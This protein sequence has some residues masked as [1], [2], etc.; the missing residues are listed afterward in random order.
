[1]R[2]PF[3]SVVVLLLASCISKAQQPQITPMPVSVQP[4]TGTFTISKNT[5]ITAQDEADRKSAAFLNDYLQQYYGLKLDVDRQEGKDYIR[6]VTRKFIQAPEKDAYQMTVAADGVTIEGDTYAGTFYG[7]QSLIQLLPVMNTRAAASD[8]RLTIPSVA[9]QDAPRFPY[10]GLHLDVGRHMFPISFIKK[11]ID[12]IALHKMNY[13]HWH[14]TEDQG[15]RIEIKK[16][17]R[18]Q[19]EAA[20]RNGTIIGRYPGTGNDNQRYGGYYT[21]EEVKEIVQYAADR[22]ITVIPEIELPGHASAAIAAYPW[23]SCFPEQKT[24]LRG[25]VSDASKAASGKTVQ[26]RWGVF[27]DVFCAGKDSTFSFLQDVF[28]EVLP[29]FPSKYIHVGGDESPKTHWEKCPNCQRRMKE[30]G[31][32]DEHELQSYFIQRIEK[33]LNAKGRTIIGWDEILEGGLAPNAIVMSWRGEEGGIAAAKQNHQ[34]IMTPGSHVYLD[35]TQSQDEDSVTIGGYTPLDKIYSYEPIPA[36]LNATQA[37][38]V[39]GAQGNVWTEYMRYPGKVEYMI[40]PRL[41]A[42]SEVLWSPKEKRSWTDFEKRLPVIFNRYGLWGANYSRAYFDIVSGIVAA[43]GNKGVQL[44]LASKDKT[45]RL[46]YRTGTGAARNYTAPVTITTPGPVSAMYYKDNRLMDSV[47]F[48]LSFNKA[49]GKKVTLKE[50]PSRNYPGDGGFTLVNG[51]QNTRGLAR[52]REFIGYNGNDLEATIDLG[53]AQKISRVVLHTLDQGGSW[54][55]PPASVEIQVS[56]DGKK[57]RPAGKTS[58]FTPVQG[59]DGVM[60]VSM[61]GTTARYV[62]V[63]AKNYG[64]IPEGKAGA[65]QKGWLF[66]DEIEIF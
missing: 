64:V 66:A 26:E 49:T 5:V 34:V 18:L 16:Y 1:M 62:R 38:Y 50:Q 36:E 13:F 61:A 23:L 2:I 7:I 48:N 28:D 41:T 15:W 30:Q 31:L 3:L 29:L 8:I 55:Y 56:T 58:S 21:Q 11:Y 9:V 54:V 43:P 14:L 57:F 59:G 47:S 40:F 37:K 20:Y 32:K 65:G 35:H 44:K 17:P 60:T 52:G 4:G 10:R 6:L 45:G 27:D 63:I 22:H 46:Q 19:E 25:P 12:Y 42:L 33:Y 51:I 39:M 53:A 24:D